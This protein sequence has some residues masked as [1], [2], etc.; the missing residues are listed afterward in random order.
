MFI[1]VTRLSGILAGGH[2]QHKLTNLS[3][4]WRPTN[5]SCTHLMIQH[6]PISTHSSLYSQVGHT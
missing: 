2:V 4:S 1:P 5:C 6:A 3:Y